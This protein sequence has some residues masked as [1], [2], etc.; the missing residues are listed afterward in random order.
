[1]ENLKNLETSLL[2]AK[3]EKNQVLISLLE[4]EISKE[5]KKLEKTPLQVA[6]EA[7]KEL[8]KSGKLAIQSFENEQ[9]FLFN[10]FN[11]YKKINLNYPELN[12]VANTLQEFENKGYK[13]INLLGLI[14]FS[15]AVNCLENGAKFSGAQVFSL[16]VDYLTLSEKR[17]S[18]V[19]GKAEKINTEFLNTKL[20]GKVNFVNFKNICEIF[21]KKATGK[22][23]EIASLKY[24]PKRFENENLYAELQSLFTDKDGDKL[25]T[26]FSKFLLDN[27]GINDK[28]SLLNILVNKEIPKDTILVDYL[29]MKRAKLAAAQAAKV[30]NR[31]TREKATKAA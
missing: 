21:D 11:F 24:N 12:K 16:V 1:M 9:K 28:T 7:N 30:E 31:P 26:R 29:E 27:F 18:E 23:F 17:Q 8:K 6:K 22:S 14:S 10:R 13:V 4:K 25:G 15:K 2:K 20:T 19:D 3:K 5:K